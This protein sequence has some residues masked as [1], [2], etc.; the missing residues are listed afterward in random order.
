VVHHEKSPS[1]VA[2]EPPQRRA[3]DET[4]LPPLSSIIPTNPSTEKVTELLSRL[5]VRVARIAAWHE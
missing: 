5:R 2:Q 4:P 1:A 3:V